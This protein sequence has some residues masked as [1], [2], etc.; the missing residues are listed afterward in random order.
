[1]QAWP[2]Y[3]SFT[4]SW[5][6]RYFSATH[7]F[8][9]HV[10]CQDHALTFFRVT[11]QTVYTQQNIMIYSAFCWSHLLGFVI[12]SSSRHHLI[13]SLRCVL[14]REVWRRQPNAAHTHTH[15]HTR[16]H[17]HTH[18]HTHARTLCNSLTHKIPLSPIS[19]HKPRSWRQRAYLKN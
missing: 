11:L 18:T 12:L 4:G 10:I 13:T 8:I 7:E 6:M 14:W 16:T 15:T 19:S 17:T 9:L 1:M 3:F 5:G 2:A